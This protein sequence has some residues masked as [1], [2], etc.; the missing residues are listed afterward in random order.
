L[1]IFARWDQDPCWHSPADDGTC[2]KVWCHLHSTSEHSMSVSWGQQLSWTEWR[3]HTCK[4]VWHVAPSDQW[5]PWCMR[6]SSVDPE[7]SLGNAAVDWEVNLDLLEQ[8][9][10]SGSGISWAI[11]ICTLSQTDNHAWIPPL[12]FYSRMPFLLPNQQCQSTEG[13]YWRP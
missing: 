3:Q 7:P 6:Q 10:V 9:T 5:C 2:T 11:C 1:V 13:T 12:S 8:Q 4:T